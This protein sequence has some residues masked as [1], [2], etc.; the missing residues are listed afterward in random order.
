MEKTQS[1]VKN[2]LPIKLRDYLVDQLQ[3]SLKCTA[4][5]SLNSDMLSVIDE[6]AKTRLF[7]RENKNLEERYLHLQKM[8]KVSYEYTVIEDMLIALNHN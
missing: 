1:R 3:N 7:S 4:Q 6:D 2:G 8:L 5:F